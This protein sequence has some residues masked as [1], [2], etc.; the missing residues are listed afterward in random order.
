MAVETF[1]IISATRW[2]RDIK[3]PLRLLDLVGK[4]LI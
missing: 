2:R 1:I 3:M 4:I